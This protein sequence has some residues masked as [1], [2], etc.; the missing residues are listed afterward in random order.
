MFSDCGGPGET[1]TDKVRACRLHTDSQSGLYLEL[2]PSRYETTAL[3]THTLYT[4][5]R[6][7]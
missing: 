2:E 6:Q 3:T 4:G 1:Q 5:N 7:T